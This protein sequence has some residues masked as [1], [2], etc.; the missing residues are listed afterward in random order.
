MV[1]IGL[2]QALAILAVAFFPVALVLVLFV[3]LGRRLS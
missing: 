3:F 1:M 2:W